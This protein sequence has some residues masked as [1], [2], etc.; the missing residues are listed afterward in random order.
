MK[1]LETFNTPSTVLSNQFMNKIIGGETYIHSTREY[2]SGS[3][4]DTL[5]TTSTDAGRTTESCLKV[6]TDRAC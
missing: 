2:C 6:D 4:C 5:Y 3:I 1:T